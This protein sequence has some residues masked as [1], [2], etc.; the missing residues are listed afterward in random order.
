MQYRLILLIMVC[1]WITS[2]AQAQEGIPTIMTERD[3]PYIDGGH[4]QRQRLD[5]YFPAEGS[6]WPV[7]LFV[8][9]GAWVVGDKSH[10]AHIGHTLAAHGMV[11]VIPNHRLSPDV[12]HPA[13]VE[14]V[15]AALAWT[16]AN[17]ENYGGDPQRIVVGGHSAGGH[18]TSL[19]TLDPEYLDAH[20]LSPELIRGV[21][22][23]STVWWIDDWITGWAVGVF[24]TDE[25]GRRAASPYYLIH[26]DAPPFLVL[27]AEHDYPELVLEAEAAIA[28]LADENV[29]VEF[30]IILDRDH[31][32]IVGHIG[33]PDDMTTAIIA[34][35]LAGLLDEE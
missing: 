25:A 31:Y 24:P 21:V 29:L 23:V 14:D 8:H 35:W 28:A 34:D 18:L 22:N 30:H 15:A 5:V 26:E 27:A 4:P 7:L 32:D 3:I 17:I 19:L 1:I 16:V 2:H 9:G 11:V 10:I 12:T 20:G 13:H 33:E 6:A